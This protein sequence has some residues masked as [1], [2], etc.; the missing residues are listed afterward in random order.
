[1]VVILTIL[2]FYLPYVSTNKVTDF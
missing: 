2:C 1:M